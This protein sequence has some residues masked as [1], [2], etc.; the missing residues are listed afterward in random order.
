M[1]AKM[2]SSQVRIRS[3]LLDKVEEKK[4]EI[5]YQLRLEIQNTDVINTLIMKHLD[6]ITQEEILEYRRKYLGKDE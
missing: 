4:W 2:S 5:K 6:D 1:E 3:E